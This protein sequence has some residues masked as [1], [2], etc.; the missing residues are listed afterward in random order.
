MYSDRYFGNTWKQL[1]GTFSKSMQIKAKLKY[2][3]FD[4][5]EGFQ[6][7]KI[8]FQKTIFSNLFLTIPNLI[9]K[10]PGINTLDHFKSPQDQ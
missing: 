6:N 8:E 4:V 9:K 2:H 3:L 5:R 7:N 10:M 1:L